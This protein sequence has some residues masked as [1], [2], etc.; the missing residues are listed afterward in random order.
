MALTG[1]PTGTGQP[2]RL[3]QPPWKILAYSYFEYAK[4]LA[5]NRDSIYNRYRDDNYYQIILQLRRR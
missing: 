3:Y 5:S 1:P 4:T 2:G